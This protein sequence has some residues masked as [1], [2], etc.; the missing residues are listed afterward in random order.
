MITALPLSLSLACCYQSD[1]LSWPAAIS[2]IAL[3][4]LDPIAV[5]GYLCAR[6]ITLLT[7]GSHTPQHTA[8]LPRSNLSQHINVSL[9]DLDAKVTEFWLGAEE[10]IHAQEGLPLQPLLPP[11]LRPLDLPPLQTVPHAPLTWE[12]HAVDLLHQAQGM[13]VDCSFHCL[14][15]CIYVCITGKTCA[16]AHLCVQ[17]VYTHMRY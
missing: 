3:H 5:H 1:T 4:C 7:R 9:L 12:S 13:P 6:S 14:T 2:R 17:S 8:C 15:L 11:H 10:D 16:V